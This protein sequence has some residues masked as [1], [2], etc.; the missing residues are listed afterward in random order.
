M[1]GVQRQGKFQGHC[2]RSV[3]IILIQM[4]WDRIWASVV[5]RQSPAALTTKEENYLRLSRTQPYKNISE[6]P[7]VSFRKCPL[8]S[9]G[10]VYCALG[11]NHERTKYCIKTKHDRL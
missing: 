4:H 10:A 7:K 5:K 1:S 6:T 3:V 11:P 8:S 9:F 2:E